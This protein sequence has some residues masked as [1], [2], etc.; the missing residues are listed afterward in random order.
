MDVCRGHLRTVRDSL[1]E[2]PAATR[3]ELQIVAHAQRPHRRNRQ[4]CFDTPGDS[5][6][7]SA[8]LY[9]VV[10]PSGAKSWAVRYRSGGRTRKHTIGRYSLFD[11]KAARE[12]A[13]KA[14]R[15][16]AEG[17]DPA[18]EKA[19]ARESPTDTVAAVAK[20]FVQEALR[21]Q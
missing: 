1:R 7:P 11:L 8:S 13:G 21:A 5:R 16:V 10:Q 9:L 15:A 4:T 18:R 3:G 20:Q 17:R 6:P 12:L 19:Q 2:Y 14:L